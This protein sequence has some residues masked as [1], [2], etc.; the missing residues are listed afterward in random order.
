MFKIT[1]LYP[2]S[3]GALFDH[4]YYRDKHLPLF[5][6]LLGDACSRYEIDRGLAG[7]EPDEAAPF[8]AMCHAFVPSIEGFQTAMA[9]HAP[10]IIADVVKYTNVKPVMQV[11]EVVV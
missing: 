6:S 5:R 2:T 9:E 1:V 8:V 10:T 11:S 4:D 7:G 3:E